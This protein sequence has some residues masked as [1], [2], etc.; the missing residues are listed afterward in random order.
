MPPLYLNTHSHATHARIQTKSPPPLLPLFKCQVKLKGGSLATGCGSDLLIP[1]R[2]YQR[3]IGPTVSLSRLGDDGLR[4]RRHDLR[5]LLLLHHLCRAG[6]DVRIRRKGYIHQIGSARQQAALSALVWQSIHPA[7]YTRQIGATHTYLAE[8]GAEGGRAPQPTEGA[9]VGAQSGPLV[10]VLD[11]LKCF[12]GV[13]GCE[14][15]WPVNRSLLKGAYSRRCTARHTLTHT[16]TQHMTWRLADLELL[17]DLGPCAQEEEL[18]RHAHLF[19][20]GLVRR[21]L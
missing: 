15:W 6:G 10:L 17:A 13:F 9:A 19:L 4:P 11:L 3:L 18:L 2:S 14:G 20:A 16:Q 5:A 12:F 8:L 7:V 21:G 1:T